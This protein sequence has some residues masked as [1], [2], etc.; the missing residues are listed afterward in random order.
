MFGHLVLLGGEPSLTSGVNRR[1]SKQITPPGK[2]PR[3]AE[4]PAEDG[5]NTERAVEEGSHRNQL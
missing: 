3:E 5:R 1:S 2:E 4:V